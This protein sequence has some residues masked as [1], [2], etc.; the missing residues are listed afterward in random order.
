VAAVT[1]EVHKP[2]DRWALWRAGDGGADL[3]AYFARP[4]DVEF[5]RGAFQARADEGR[6]PDPEPA[7]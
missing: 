3:V 7:D 6:E 2:D 4:E 1:Y 5:A